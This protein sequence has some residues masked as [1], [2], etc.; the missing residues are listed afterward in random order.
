MTGETTSNIRTETYTLVKLTNDELVCLPMLRQL[1]ASGAV[2][3][4][5]GSFQVHLD[6]DGNVRKIEEH[7]CWTPER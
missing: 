3:L 6:F 4:R 1:I 5:G 7:K 2:N